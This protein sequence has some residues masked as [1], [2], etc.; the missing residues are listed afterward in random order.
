MTCCN[1]DELSKH[2]WVK[3]A[4][5]GRLHTV[6]FVYMKCS[7]KAGRKAK[8]QASVGTEKAYIRTKE[9]GLLKASLPM[10]PD[11]QVVVQRTSTSGTHGPGLWDPEPAS[12]SQNLSSWKRPVS[13][14]REELS[15]G[16]DGLW[17]WLPWLPS[18]DKSPVHSQLWVQ[19]MLPLLPSTL[20][21]LLP[22][23]V[24]FGF[25]GIWHKWGHT[26]YTL[27]DEVS[28]TQHDVFVIHPCCCLLSGICSVSYF[29]RLSMPQFVSWLSYGW[30]PGMFPGFAYYN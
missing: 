9:K 1:M 10:S 4:R 22:L 13:I 21:G 25:S 8:Q 19:S 17:E 14:G 29:S 20:Q 18:V 6:W 24:S 30:T 12:V 3:E 7:A 27:S 15:L 23:Q 5:H 26:A 16:K 2:C 28:F 11:E